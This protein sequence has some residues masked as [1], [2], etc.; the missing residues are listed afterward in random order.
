MLKT[1]CAF[2]A[3]TLS[4]EGPALAGSCASPAEA[5]ALR[6]AVIQQELMVAAYQCHEAAAYNRFVISYRGELQASDAA[7][8]TYFVRRGGEAG[9]DSFKTKAANVFG[10]EQAR[11]ADAFCASAHALFAEAFANRGSL[12]RFVESQ[13]AGSGKV[14]AE[15][16]TI[17]SAATQ[18]ALKPA[19]VIVAEA[20]PTDDDDGYAAPQREE[21]QPRRSGRDYGYVPPPPPP[22]VPFRF[23]W[24]RW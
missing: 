1:A 8:K 12:T 19:R 14:C 5:T 23:G 11:H 22:S 2:L 7:L 18:P 4:L 24:G 13:S 15:P 21:A 9:Y 16:R 6:A 10:L 17:L 20:R 3:L